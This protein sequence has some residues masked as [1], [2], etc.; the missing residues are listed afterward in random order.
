MHHAV[1]IL[2]VEVDAARLDDAVRM[3]GDAIDSRRGHGAATFQVATVNPEFVMRARR[4][5]PFRRVLRDCSLRTADGVG[6]TLAAR[7]LGH[8]L[9]ERVAGVELVIALARAAVSR[10]DRVFLL[11]GEPGVAEAA[12]ERL[13]QLAPG[14][15]AVGTLAGD[16]SP[17]GDAEALAAIKTAAPDIILV[18]FGAPAQELW[19]QRNLPVSGAAVGIGVGGTLDYL[20]GRARRA[21]RWMRRAGLEWLFRLVTQ[22]RRAGRMTVLPAFL[23][24]VLRQR[25]LRK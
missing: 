7:L 18:A 8:P 10:G 3:I 22:P 4:D 14:F 11:G 15:Q 20:A 16:S 12:A 17:E 1:R 21:P 13:A 2:D 19:N 25:V 5:M 23:L 6:I 9:P 24:L